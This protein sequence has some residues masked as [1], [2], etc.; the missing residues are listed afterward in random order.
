MSKKHTTKKVPVKIKRTEKPLPPAKDKQMWVRKQPVLW[1]LSAA[2]VT[3]AVCFIPMLKNHFTNWDDEYYVINNTLLRGP[4]WHGIFTQ[5]VVS[6]YHPLTII[7]LAINYALTGTDPSSYLVFNLLLHLINTALVFYLVWVLSNR[8]MWVAFL[9]AL[10][11]GIHPLH[12]ESVAWVSERKDVLYTL[13]FL[14]SL[15]QYWKFLQ[16]GKSVRLWFCFFLFAVSLLS[17]PAAIVLPLVLLLLDYWKGRE[18]NLRLFLEK[19]PFFILALIFAIITVKIQSAKAIAGLNL[20]PLWT[21][22]LFATYVLMIYLVR[23]LIPYPLS[24]FHPY[25]RPDHLGWAVWASPVLILAL[26]A[27]IWLKR[28]NKVVLFGFLFFVVNLLLVLQVVSIGTTIV[29]ERYT[30]VPYIGI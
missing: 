29:S 24:A 11:F 4:D 15:L 22:P 8:K 18:I 5:P 9:T 13:F 28:K 23:F 26:I 7:S 30:Y 21:R 2:I 12:V 1:L 3:T 14:L 20:Y 27:F 19:I 10:I 6:N 16:T 25:P 17:K